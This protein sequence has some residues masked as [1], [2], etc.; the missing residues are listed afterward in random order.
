MRWCIAQEDD[1]HWSVYKGG[2]MN[3]EKHWANTAEDAVKLMLALE[4]AGR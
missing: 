1:H 3:G 2:A 4:E